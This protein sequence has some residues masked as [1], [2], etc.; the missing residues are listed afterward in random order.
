M[1]QHPIHS[2]RRSFLHGTARTA[3]ALPL[4]ASAF[5]ERGAGAAGAAPKRV[6]FVA[7]VLGTVPSRFFPPGP[8]GK[9]F[10]ED[11]RFVTSDYKLS[12]ILLPFAPLQKEVTVVQNISHAAGGGGHDDYQQLLVQRPLVEKAPRVGV[13]LDT[14]IAKQIGSQTPVSQL[15]LGVQCL[16]GA[17]YGCLSWFADGN[18]GLDPENE[19]AKVFAR[20]F[21]NVKAD[22]TELLRARA[23]RKSVL[24]AAL[25]QIKTLSARIGQQDR[26]KLAAYADSLR[27]VE[28]Q[29]DDLAAATCKSPTIA[30]I[31][32]GKPDGA[33]IPNAPQ[34]S[35]IASTPLIAKTQID[36]LVQAFM[37]DLTRVGVLQIGF[38]GTLIPHPWLGIKDGFHDLSHGEDEASHAKQEKISHWNAEIVAYLA[39][40][41]AAI[42]EGEGTALDNTLI[43]W[44]HSLTLGTHSTSSTPTVLIG[45]R[46]AGFAPGKFIHEPYQYA[47]NSFSVNRNMPDLF[48]AVAKGFGVPMTTFGEPKWNRQPLSEILA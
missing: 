39:T 3:L 18:K 10:P 40:Q 20:L 42:P 46:K 21:A 37:C 27:A 7:S 23:Q 25:G 28:K 38:E 1:S 2:S 36:L 17:P 22:P 6:V 47:P 44:L 29:L 4:F 9:L 35:A 43:V 14:L 34:L 30:D 48:V 45:G 12:P 15:N 26:D 31:P 33:S 19:P 5:G 11:K 8:D 24:D 32:F 16:G 41:L 13:S